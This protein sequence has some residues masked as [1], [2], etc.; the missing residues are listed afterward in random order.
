MKKLFKKTFKNI[1]IRVD[2]SYKIG[3]GHLMRCLTLAEQLKD[4]GA[5]ISFICRELDGNC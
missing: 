2:S 5:D 1:Y 3:S 4:A